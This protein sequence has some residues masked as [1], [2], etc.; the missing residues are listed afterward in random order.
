MVTI[1]V[2]CSIQ[3]TRNWLASD[4]W[5]FILPIM[6]GAPSLDHV[7]LLLVQAWLDVVLVPDV[8]LAV[9][10]DL[11]VGVTVHPARRRATDP[12]T[13][14]VVESTVAGAEEELLVGEP[15]H[16]TPE[17]R[18]G[19]A[20]DVELAHDLLALG[21]RETLALLVQDGRAL[22][23]T[24]Y[25]AG[26]PLPALLLYGSLPGEPDGVIQLVVHVR[27]LGAG[28][29]FLY[30]PLPVGL[31]QGERDLEVR[32][33]FCRDLG[34]R[35]DLLPAGSHVGLAQQV[36]LDDRAE[37][38]RGGGYGQYGPDYRSHHA[39]AEEVAAGYGISL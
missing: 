37:D 11:G 18:A 10:P 12:P 20:E 3:S 38:E 1:P 14:D 30:G 28:M 23:L 5:V 32:G 22:R 19:V 13:V 33:L 2:R 9:L 26:R 17:V 27:L 36:G 31:F 21:F 15:S 39:E 6:L 16:G 8:E 25:V 34:D 4:V 29:L 7:G 24:Q 35:G